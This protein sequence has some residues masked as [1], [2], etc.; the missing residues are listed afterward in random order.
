MPHRFNP[1]FSFQG[2]SHS[3][4][5]CDIQ[6]VRFDASQTRLRGGKP[7]QAYFTQGLQIVGVPPSLLQ[8]LGRYRL[9]GINLRQAQ[10]HTRLVTSVHIETATAIHLLRV[11]SG[12]VLAYPEGVRA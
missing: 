5:L 12:V 4:P 7:V 9:D 11:D 1:R 2:S 6:D 3:V 10:T 8:V